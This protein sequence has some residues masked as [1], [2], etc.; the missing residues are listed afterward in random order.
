MA[1][2]NHINLQYSE[3]QIRLT[4]LTNI[5]RMLVTRGFMS[6]SKYAPSNKEDEKKQDK[7]KGVRSI[8]VEHPTGKDRINNT[9]FL[10]FIAARTDNNIYVIPLDT[11]YRDQREAKGEANI[12]FDGSVII[13][14]I[15]PQIV[16]DISNSPI[17]N[18]FFK[19]YNKN[20]KIIVFDGMSDK[21]F[22]VLSKKKNVE[23]FGRDFFMMDIMSHVNAPNKVEF[24]TLADISHMTN[25]KL[26]KI[27][28][29]DPTCMYFNGKQ[30]QILR[31]ISP[32]INN[33][34]FVNYRKVVA[35]KSGAF[36]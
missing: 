6:A 10:P 22:N 7:D 34:V 9:L 4:V 11:P 12:D 17:L 1:S 30:G 19:S 35:P 31:T 29:N 5:C 15:I 14:K 36:K 18:D 8:T 21:V 16:K 33:C 26:A 24:V 3:E 27:H 25:P 13:I 32:S 2:E 23:S 20:H 28:E